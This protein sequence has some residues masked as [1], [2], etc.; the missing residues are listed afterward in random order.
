MSGYCKCEGLRYFSHNGPCS[1]AMLIALAAQWIAAVL[2]E[3]VV[4]RCALA[5]GHVA[6]ILLDELLWFMLQIVL[7]P[8]RLIIDIAVF[9]MVIDRA[10][11]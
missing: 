7:R 9:G 2:P 1:R 5:S 11:G 8:G 10:V 4:V 3:R 6:G